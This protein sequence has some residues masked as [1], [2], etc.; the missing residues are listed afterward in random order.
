[1]DP[2]TIDD[3]KYLY[4]IKKCIEIYLLEELAQHAKNNTGFVDCE[5]KT[6]VVDSGDIKGRLPDDKYI[7]ETEYAKK[8]IWWHE[9]GSDNEKI[10][11]KALESN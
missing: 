3:N 9:D 2:S 6:L 8:N 11:K 1:M 7:V 4:T 5:G 10:K